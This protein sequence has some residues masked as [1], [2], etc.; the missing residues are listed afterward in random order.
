MNLVCLTGEIR[1]GVSGGDYDS[2]H[3]EERLS[4]F[5]RSDPSQG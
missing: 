5:H 4:M 3:G 1:G 2:Y